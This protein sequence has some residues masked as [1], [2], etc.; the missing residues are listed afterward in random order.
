[1]RRKR[2]RGNMILETVIFMPFLFILLVGMLRVGEITYLDY[3]IKKALFTT[4][5]YLA[6]QQGVDFCSDSTGLIA[7]AKNFGLTGTSDGSV[8]SFLPSLTIDQ[9]DV[10][11]ECYDPSTQTVSTCNLPCDG[12]AAN[13]VRPDFIVVS[14]P[15]GYTVNPRI[16][17]LLNQEIPLKPFVRVPFGGT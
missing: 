12:A 6:T 5:Q 15:S 2:E 14:I 3:Q 11:A 17:Y 4:A 8:G 10:A 9:V 1:M 16:P 13:V 7:A